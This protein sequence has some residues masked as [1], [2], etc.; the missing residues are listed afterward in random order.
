MGAAIGIGFYRWLQEQDKTSS[1]DDVTAGEAARK[2]AGA[3][4]NL[5]GLVSEATRGFDK[6]SE[7]DGNS[8]NGISDPL[9]ASEVPASRP[10]SGSSPGSAVSRG[11][12][13]PSAPVT[14]AP[15]PKP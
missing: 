8:A 14:P 13:A 7:A 6:A 12:R 15:P 4:R 10:G 1:P 11:S 9:G 3:L 2:M 5:A